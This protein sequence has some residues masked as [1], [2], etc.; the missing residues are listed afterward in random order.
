M[1]AKTKDEWLNWYLER[2]GDEELELFPNEI[3]D[4]HPEHGFIVYQVDTDKG[5]LYSHHTCG[6]GKYWVRI[7]K[8]IME[9]YGLKKLIGYTERNPEA[10][11][12]KYGG[13]IKGYDLE[14]NIDELKV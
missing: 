5:V 7:Y 11:I 9:L 10:W 12:R 8:S 14:V 13:H 4:F 1:T 3:I 6:D 2:T